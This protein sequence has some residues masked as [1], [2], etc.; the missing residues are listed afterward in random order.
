MNF[1]F[2]GNLHVQQI[3]I[4]LPPA[5]PTVVPQQSPPE[6]TVPESTVPESV[7]SGQASPEVDVQLEFRPVR[8]SNGRQLLQRLR[9]SRNS[10]NSRNET[11]ALRQSMQRSM[12]SLFDLMQPY[13]SL[14]ENSGIHELFE[15][16]R[17]N[18]A[19]TPTHRLILQHLPYADSPGGECA[20]CA[21]ATDQPW[22]KLEPCGHLFHRSCCRTWLT[23][24]NTCPLCRQTVRL[25]TDHLSLHE[26]LEMRNALGLPR[27]EVVERTDLERQLQEHLA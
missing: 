16:D 23:E 25:N 5:P 11:G 6:S 10:R 19:P 12:G 1:T 18:V 17:D 13:E 8:R 7:A 3:Q 26:L 22:T 4:Q 15:A 27:S 20:I 24:H 2:H 9:N 21:E 14:L